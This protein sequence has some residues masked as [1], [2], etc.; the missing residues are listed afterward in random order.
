MSG[1]IK[2]LIFKLTDF[3]NSQ[4]NFNCQD[5]LRLKRCELLFTELISWITSIPLLQCGL[6]MYF[7]KCFI[8][9]RI[10]AKNE[11][12]EIELLIT[13]QLLIYVNIKNVYL[14][15]SLLN[16]KLNTPKTREYSRFP[17]DKVVR[18][19]NWMKIIRIHS[20]HISP[21]NYYSYWLFQTIRQIR[22]FSRLENVERRSAK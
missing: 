21:I 4:R 13:I 15:L 14:N 5:A 17:L 9:H 16:A 12:K 2:Q 8:T 11:H 6:P 22:S 3:L 19:N 10:Y 1:N 18:S 7:S 20:I